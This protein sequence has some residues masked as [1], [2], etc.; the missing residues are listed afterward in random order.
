MREEFCRVC[1]QNFTYGYSTLDVCFSYRSLLRLSWLHTNTQANSSLQVKAHYAE[2]RAALAICER[3]NR[4]LTPSSDEENEGEEET[5]PYDSAPMDGISVSK[6]PSWK[7]GPNVEGLYEEGP[8]SLFPDKEYEVDMLTGVTDFHEAIVESDSESDGEPVPRDPSDF[9]LNPEIWRATPNAS[10]E[11]PAI[12]QL[13]PS[14]PEE[15][16]SGRK[17]VRS[18]AESSEDEVSE[19]ES[20]SRSEEDDTF[21]PSK[22]RDSG[23]EEEEEGV[24]EDITE[25]STSEPK[26]KKAKTEKKLKIEKKDRKDSDGEFVAGDEEED[27][28]DEDSGLPTPG[29]DEPVAGEEDT[30]ESLD[31][32]APKKGKKAK[33]KTGKTEEKGDGVFKPGKSTDKDEDETVEIDGEA[34]AAGNQGKKKYCPACWKCVHSFGV[35][36]FS[37]FSAFMIHEWA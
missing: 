33:G 23:S 27:E 30:E 18:V 21:D 35:S 26:R 22:T 15:M 4:L 34:G 37:L 32:K 16:V 25:T 1:D 5:E 6:T 20:G 10:P 13:K 12:R 24:P 9:V 3:R 36:F 28:D 19:P 2:H 14:Y 11:I 17:R 8:F 7:D 31:V 29:V